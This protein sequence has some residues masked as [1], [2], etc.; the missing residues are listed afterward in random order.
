MSP[1]KIFTLS[2]TSQF[3]KEEEKMEALKKKKIAE[4]LPNIKIPEKESL[5]LGD[6]PNMIQRLAD[7]QKAESVLRSIIAGTL[8]VQDSLVREQCG[9]AHLDHHQ[10]HGNYVDCKAD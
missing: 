2:I 9:N 3:A 4:E 5:K 10:E 6:L 8:Y 7:L 1:V